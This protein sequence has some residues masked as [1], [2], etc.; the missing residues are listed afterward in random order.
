MNRWFV[1]AVAVAIAVA[2][3]NLIYQATHAWPE[4]TES[5]ALRANNAA[6]VRV[7]MWPYLVILLGPP[8]VPV[9][10]AGLVAFCRRPQ[11]RALRFL[12]A[13]FA[14]LLAETFLAGAQLYYPDTCSPIIM[15]VRLMFARGMAGMT[16]ASA[17]RRFAMARSRQCWSATAIG[18]PAGPIGAVPQGWNWVDTV[19]R[20]Y[21]ASVSSEPTV[22]SAS[23]ATWCTW[24]AIFG[25]WAT[26]HRRTARRYA[27]I[28][29]PA[30]VTAQLQRA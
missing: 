8:L 16:D 20:T 27:E 4:L 9:W 2:V 17:T 13:A 15:Q 26:C 28:V 29:H 30:A 14:V 5:R 23:R 21:A 19:A 11:W 24:R 1:L 18:S 22:S 6:P 10:V 25:W 7:A 3:P 12:P